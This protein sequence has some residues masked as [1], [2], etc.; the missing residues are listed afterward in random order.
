MPETT[1]N[2]FAEREVNR[3]ANKG[4]RKKPEHPM[5]HVFH[6]ECLADMEGGRQTVT[7][8]LAPIGCELFDSID[9]RCPSDPCR[10]CKQAHPSRQAKAG[11]GFVD[12]GGIQTSIAE[13]INE[14]KPMGRIF[15]VSR[16][17]E[18]A[19]GL[20]IHV[21][22]VHFAMEGHCFWIPTKQYNEIVSTPPI[23]RGSKSKAF[24][25]PAEYI[26]GPVDKCLLSIQAAIVRPEW[27]LVFCDHNVQITFHVM[28]LK[29]ICEEKDFQLWPFLWSVGH[30]PD[31]FRERALAEAGWEEWRKSVTRQ[32]KGVKS[33]YLAIKSNAKVFNGLGAQETCDVL[34]RALIHPLMPIR[35]VCST[36][37][38]WNRLTTAIRTHF[39][40]VE[41]LVFKLKP[42][43]AHVSS[44]L[45]IRMMD[46]QHQRFV[47]LGV[48]SYR[49]SSV[50]VTGQWL[51]DA[52]E[53]NLF[54]TNGYID[55]SEGGK[56]ATKPGRERK[57]TVPSM[58]TL[59]AG[60][61]T[62]IPNYEIRMENGRT[63]CYTPFTAQIDPKWAQPRKLTKMEPARDIINLYNT[64]TIGPYS[65]MAFIANSWTTN[66]LN[67]TEQR[68]WVKFKP[69]KRVTVQVGNF[70]LRR[71]TLREFR[72]KI[73]IQGRYGYKT[74]YKRLAE[75]AETTRK[76]GGKHFIKKLYRSRGGVGGYA[77]AKATPGSKVAKARQVK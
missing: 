66:H 36:E 60:A 6:L 57:L 38:I 37:S 28:K 27:T 47:R 64:T 58:G 12:N 42:P 39:S 54:D 25:V 69:G 1:V 15:C 52:H 22:R 9:G 20:G 3:I 72:S 10:N 24:R 68:E 7:A 49:R 41:E 8:H 44:Q 31:A 18:M 67:A 17:K 56:A 46:R 29:K 43:L 50:F 73:R 34:T 5:E 65:F 2:R 19:L 40:N 14:S 21:I 61:R 48:F 35:V 30:G 26:G 55:A 70:R 11:P 13:V 75:D 62:H 63:K 33:A 45:P 59:D 71:P 74:M 23:G 51:Q 77:G 76:C 4:G 32:K 53:L 16:G